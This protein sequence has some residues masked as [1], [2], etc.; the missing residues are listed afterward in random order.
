MCVSRSRPSTTPPYTGTQP[1]DLPEPAPRGV[2]Y[3]P[4]AAH[5]RTTSA[6]SAVFAG[7]TTTS[8]N[9]GA[10]FGVSSRA[11]LARSSSSVL[12]YVAPTIPSSVERKP[13]GNGLRASGYGGPPCPP[14]LVSGVV[15][16]ATYV[17]ATSLASAA[18]SFARCVLPNVVGA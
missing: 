17:V 16:R 10:R 6:T 11:H 14:L 12:A 9:D 7:R 2:T 5:A 1:P 18:S 3:T 4:A 13:A 8:G 15:T